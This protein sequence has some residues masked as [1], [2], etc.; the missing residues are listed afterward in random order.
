MEPLKTT[1][2]YRE[3]WYRWVI[4][5]LFVVVSI[6]GGFANSTCAPITDQVSDIYGVSIIWVEMNTMVYELVFIIAI[7]PSNYITDTF[8][9]R[10]SVSITQV[11]SGAALTL[12]GSIVRLGA[13]WSF[14]PVLIGNVFVA[15]GMAVASGCTAKISAFWFR[16]AWVCSTQRTN[17]TM[18]ASIANGVGGAIGL[19]VPPLFVTGNNKSQFLTLLLFEAGLSVVCCGAALIFMRNRPPT[20]P[21][22]SGAVKREAFVPALKSVMTN[23]PFLM[24]LG[25]VSLSL[26]TNNVFNTVVEIV[27]VPYGF[28]SVRFTQTDA[29]VLGGVMTIS[30]LLG[31]LITSPI[32]GR[33][34]KYKLASLL[35]NIFAAAGTFIFA[36][37]LYVGNIFL[38]S[39]CVAVIGFG[40]MPISAFMIELACE[41]TYPVGEAMSTGLLNMA[42]K[43]SASSGPS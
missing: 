24:T 4:L 1:E 40:M 17:A 23:F 34:R 3:Y 27:I 38:S 22:P 5:T 15:L 19:L 13:Q 11:N 28:N 31:C 36:F 33:T 41:V 8:E 29:G 12:V 37:T 6:A 2:E 43:S 16:P 42:D 18:I 21:S 39:F 10:V 20:P 25:V 32:V 35:I 26:G 30:G 7:F 9:I 14:W